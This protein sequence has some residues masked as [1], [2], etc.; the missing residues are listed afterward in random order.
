MKS[1]FGVHSFMKMYDTF[2]V[3]GDVVRSTDMEG[4]PFV[5]QTRGTREACLAPAQG[6]VASS[7]HVCPTCLENYGSEIGAGV[8]PSGPVLG[9][10]GAGYGGDKA[11]HLYI[12]SC[13]WKKLK[14]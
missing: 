14:C 3:G 4:L 13:T 12:H 2:S 6:E 7:T 10:P 5:P 9:T 8:W 11:T 1:I